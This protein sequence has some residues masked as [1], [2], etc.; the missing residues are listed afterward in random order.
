MRSVHLA[1]CLLCVCLVAGGR[2]SEDKP[3]IGPEDLEGS[4]SYTDQ[5]GQGQGSWV[6]GFRDANGTLVLKFVRQFYE[7]EP[8][9]EDYSIKG[10]VARIVFRMIPFSQPTAS[11]DKLTFVLKKTNRRD[12]EGQ[13]FGE[14][15]AGRIVTWKKNSRYMDTKPFIGIWSH[16]HEISGNRRTHVLRCFSDDRGRPRFDF[17][18]QYYS[19]EP[20]FTECSISKDLIEVE[21]KLTGYDRGDDS[22]HSLKYVLRSENG[23]LIGQLHESWGEPVDMT[24]ARY[25][26]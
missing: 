26:R 6:R 16:P 5:V 22:G 21:F 9:F 20:V 10:D 17:L 15:K 14:G 23:A 2:R 12:L 3:A 24:L 1:I 19:S 7:G 25:G 4:W 13:V 18:R 11:E 8:V